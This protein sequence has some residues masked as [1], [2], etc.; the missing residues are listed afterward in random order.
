[1]V[2]LTQDETQENPKTKAPPKGIP[3]AKWSALI[4]L[5]LGSQEVH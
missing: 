1:M 5:I 4:P 3:S 2:F